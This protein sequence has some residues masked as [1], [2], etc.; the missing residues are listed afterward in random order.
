M[1]IIPIDKDILKL[2][3]KIIEQNGFIITFNRH[4]AERML[5]P[6]VKIESDDLK[7]EF[8]MEED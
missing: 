8:T 3:D 1:K 2:L 7:T 5:N 4:L 6:L